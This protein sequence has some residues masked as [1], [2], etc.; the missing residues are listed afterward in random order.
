MAESHCGLRSPCK[1]CPERHTAC[2]GRCAK[3][4]EWKAMHL[5]QS[6][7]EKEY[8]RRSR[9]D[10][11]RSEQKHALNRFRRAGGEQ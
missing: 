2:W 6:E 11:L 1:N 5:K 10:F 3:Y 8:K 4:Q 7:A 9:E